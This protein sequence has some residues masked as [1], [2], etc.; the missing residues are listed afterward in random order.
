MSI[1]E[2]W[3]NNLYYFDRKCSCFKCKVGFFLFFNNERDFSFLY[4]IVILSVFLGP[5]FSL[6]PTQ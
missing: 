4:A 3:G 5:F 1:L 6:K 2:S